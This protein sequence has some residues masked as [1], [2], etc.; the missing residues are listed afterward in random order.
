[1]GIDEHEGRPEQ[2]LCVPAE[3]AIP[4]PIEVRYRRAEVLG[5]LEHN[6]L[7]REPVAP[8]EAKDVFFERVLESPLGLRPFAIRFGVVPPALW[9]SLSSEELLDPRPAVQVL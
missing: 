4:G 6:T 3:P 5:I 8:G 1:M 9:R 2:L 7:H